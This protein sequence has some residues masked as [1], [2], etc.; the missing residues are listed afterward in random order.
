MKNKHEHYVGIAKKISEASKDPSSKVGALILDRD[1]QP[2]S[3]GYNG[4][5][6]ECDE[7]L[8][9]WERPMK[10][11][12][13]THAEMN[14]VIFAKRD[15]KGCRLFLTHGPCSDC[16]KYVLQ[17]K[18]REIYYEDPSIV[19]LRGGLDQKEAISRLIRATGAK[20]ENISTGKS[21]IEELYEI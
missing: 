5:V 13:V 7:S 9:T 8:M 15:L 3:H 19:K 20:V 11:F 6:A 10:Y 17:A 16:L 1:N 2:V 12:M 4:F 14:A 18:I 21:Y